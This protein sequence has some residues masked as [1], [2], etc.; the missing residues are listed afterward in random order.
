MT[1]FTS[2]DFLFPKQ[3]LLAKWPVIACDQ[4]TSER[5]YWDALE[6]EVGEAP[7]ALRLIYPEIYLSEDEEKKRQRIASIEQH[8]RD[9]LTSGLLTENRDCFV[10]IE[11]T[12]LDGQ[13]R[14]GLLGVIDLEAYSYA[15]DADT[16]IRATER[17][18]PERIPPRVRIRENAPL[19]L[20]HVLLFADDPEDAILGPLEKGKEALPLC[21]DLDLMLG[22]GRLRGYLVSGEAAALTRARIAAYEEMRAAGKTHPVLYLV[23]DGNHSLAT[24]KTCYEAQKK[25][26]EGEAQLARSRYAMVELGNVRDDS[27]QFEPIH[28]LVKGIDGKA[29][30]ARIREG[31]TADNGFRVAWQIGEEKGE[32]FLDPAKGALPVG[33]LQSFLD[34][35]AEIAPEQMDYIHGED[36][37]AA[38]SAQAGNIGFAVPAIS[39]DAF[40]DAIERDGV[41]P[42]KTFSIG[43]AQEKR[44]Y[45]EARAIRCVS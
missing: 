45:L 33:I 36:S 24:A 22:G 32:I 21:Y 34:S 10:Y 30:L 17:T 8:M 5:D 16:K 35:D 39:K 18:V 27:L 1:T 23:G 4:F 20:S 37:L 41:L 38:L 31:I 15:P 40:F 25:A 7:S 42:R 19:E 43:H 6:R 13:I 29:L 26:G 44:Y 3:E 28:R 12:L 9:A 14:R 11:R 2:A